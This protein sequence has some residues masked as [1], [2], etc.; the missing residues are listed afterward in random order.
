MMTSLDEKLLSDINNDWSEAFDKDDD[1]DSDRGGGGPNDEA[2]K[3]GVSTKLAIRKMNISEK[4][5]AIRDNIFHPNEL[6]RLYIPSEVPW[7]MRDVQNDPS[8]FLIEIPQREKNDSKYDDLVTDDI[9]LLQNDGIRSFSAKLN[10]MANKTKKVKLSSLKYE[11]IYYFKCNGGGNEKILWLNAA[12]KLDRLAEDSAVRR[13]I[14]S[15][16]VTSRNRSVTSAATAD[17]RRAMERAL[18]VSP[19]LAGGFQGMLDADALK[20]AVCSDGDCGSYNEETGIDDALLSIG[21]GSSNGD[22]MDSLTPVGRKEHKVFPVSAYPNRWMT[23][24]ELKEE[25]LMPSKVFHDLRVDPG[26]SDG[27]IGTLRVEILECIGLPKMDRFSN[28][29][30]VCYLIC[31]PYGFTTD[32]M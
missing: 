11:K 16:T 3:A 24:S 30:A 18:S 28:T 4:M 21:S 25:M 20:D 9:Q 6:P 17:R 13:K 22:A 2:K 26:Q 19:R 8:M 7:T 1:I 32:T 31:G 29:D 5:T 10:T 27:E 12:R 14:S 15:R 23:E